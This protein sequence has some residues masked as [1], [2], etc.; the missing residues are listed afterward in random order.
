[1]P[2]KTIQLAGH[3]ILW[4]VHVVKAQMYCLI[5]AH[6]LY[7]PTAMQGTGDCERVPRLKVDHYIYCLSNAEARD[8]PSCNTSNETY[9]EGNNAE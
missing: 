1:M 7:A 9:V 3:D 8:E 6:D 4:K 5:L 2:D